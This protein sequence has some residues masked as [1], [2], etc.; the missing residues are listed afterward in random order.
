M[1]LKPAQNHDN[2]A[3]L[4]ASCLQNSALYW[5]SRPLHCCHVLTRLSRTGL[6][7]KRN[8][9][10]EHHG[11]NHR[12]GRCGQHMK[13]G[14]RACR[15]MMSAMPVTTAA[16]LTSASCWGAWTPRPTCKCARSCGYDRGGPTSARRASRTPCAGWT[17]PSS[18]SGWR[19]RL[20]LEARKGSSGGGVRIS[21]ALPTLAIAWLCQDR[22]TVQTPP[23][24]NEMGPLARSLHVSVLI[25]CY[26]QA[27]DLHPSVD[28]SEDYHS[29]CPLRVPKDREICPP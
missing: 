21:P 14:H 1:R 16:I 4:L 11:C 26:C 6:P 20:G 22:R 9:N 8:T 19:Q 10:S 29:P 27:S 5:P 7:S 15:P 24:L 12:E 3:A 23:P 25:T 28:R 17:G 18:Q 2:S 13:H